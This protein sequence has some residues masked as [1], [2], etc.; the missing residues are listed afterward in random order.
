MTMSSPNLAWQPVPIMATPARPYQASS[1]QALPKTQAAV[2]HAPA[3][4]SNPHHHFH[5]QFPVGLAIIGLLGLTG[6]ASPQ[7]VQPLT[8]RVASSYVWEFNGIDMGAMGFPRTLKAVSRGANPYDPDTDPVAQQLSGLQ[9]HSYILKQ[10]L[11]HLNWLNGYEEIMREI[12]S[13]PGCVM[14]STA[15]SVA[16]LRPLSRLLDLPEGRRAMDLPNEQVRT[17]AKAFNTFAA[18]QPSALKTQPEQLAKAFYTQLFTA[19]VQDKA[20]LDTAVDLSFDA[21]EA[22]TDPEYTLNHAHFNRLVDAKFAEFAHLKTLPRGL[23]AWFSEKPN[24]HINKRTTVREAIDAWSS[25]MAEHLAYE[26][27]GTKKAAMLPGTAAWSKNMQAQ[28]RLNYTSQVLEKAVIEINRQHPMTHQLSSST[29]PIKLAD[30]IKT[31]DLTLLKHKNGALRVVDKFRDVMGSA[32]RKVSKGETIE[33]AVRVTSKRTRGGA[34][35]MALA[36]T[37]LSTGYLWWLSHAIQ[38]GREYPANHN[39]SLRDIPAAAT[40]THVSTSTSPASSA[41]KLS[42]TRGPVA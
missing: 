19:G 15:I 21:L 4:Q 8:E 12:A 26:I 16:L 6:V 41:F 40:A 33:Q 32:F 39:L 2:T 17:L 38:K 7:L 3:A 36:F 25:A 9:R 1:P 29:W 20:L 37:G 23:T 14:L 31:M 35:A 28:S 27:D 11:H 42:E 22:A 10:K 13:G 24:T 5:V 30:G 18:S 34:W